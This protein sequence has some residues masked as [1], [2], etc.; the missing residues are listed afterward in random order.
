MELQAGWKQGCLGPG[1]GNRAN[2]QGDTHRQLQARRHRRVV[3]Q[4]NKKSAKECSPGAR[5]L[6]PRT[7]GVQVQEKVRL[8]LGVVGLVLPVR[9]RVTAVPSQSSQRRP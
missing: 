8:H 7:T 4:F 2:Q 3:A 1:R 9:L 6:L 5:F